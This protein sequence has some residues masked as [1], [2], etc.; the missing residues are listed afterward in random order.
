MPTIMEFMTISIAILSLVMAYLGFRDKRSDKTDKDLADRI[1][2][3]VLSDA[4]SVKASV[5][6]DAANL[7]ASILSDAANIKAIEIKEIQTNIN[8]MG[9]KLSIIEDKIIFLMNTDSKLQKHIVEDAI[10][11]GSLM[12][13]APILAKLEEKIDKVIERELDAHEDE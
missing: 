4:A 13:L 9:N 3:T 8:S 1:K 2:A 5:L 7:K 12:S 11:H 6:S 10:L